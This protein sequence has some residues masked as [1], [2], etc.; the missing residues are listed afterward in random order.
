MARS[1]SA[2]SGKALSRSSSSAAPR[3]CLIVFF[4]M[5]A[6]IGGII[7]Y[8]A[9]VRAVMQM[10]DAQ[11]WVETDCVILDSRVESHTDSDGTT[12]SAEIRYGYTYGGARYE[13]DRYRFFTSSGSRSRAQAIVDRFPAGRETICFVDP[14][15]P[16]EAVLLRDYSWDMLLGLIPLIFLIV[17]LGG[18]FFTLRSGRSRWRKSAADRLRD[19]FPTA[20]QDS[21]RLEAPPRRE[22]AFAATADA[23]PSPPRYEHPDGGQ[24]ADEEEGEEEDHEAAFIEPRR[25]PGPLTL[26]PE[27]SPLGSFLA[28]F[29]FSLVWNGILSVFLYQAIGGF[30]RG[31]PEWFLSLF[32]IPF[33]VI[34]AVML[35]A[36][37]HSFLALF[38][39][40]PQLTL[41]NGDLSLG[42]QVQLRWQFSGNTSSIR[43]LRITLRGTE[44]AKYRRGTSTHT[45]TE[46]FAELPIVETSH[47]VDMAAGSS[48]LTIPRRTMHSF[49]SGN[50]EILW[51]LRIHGTIAFWPDVDLA[52]PLTIHPPA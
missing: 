50:N 1:R 35:V 52:F 6:L 2:I 32:L 45:D 34:G 8:F 23:R 9:F 5:F 24:H 13:S 18:I 49:Q 15:R 46:V 48:T 20:A 43:H 14:Q 37:C 30:L 26:K 42:D 27:S 44:K 7:F 16:H 3:G 19:E 40:R 4:G 11:N 22:P 10:R 51:A 33:V 39:P 12:Y 47:P 21:H 31:R 28:V 17:G 36:A 41:D 25:A 38:N 29:L